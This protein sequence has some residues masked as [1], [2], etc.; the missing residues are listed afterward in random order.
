MR[1]I[2]LALFVFVLVGVAFWSCSDSTSE[3]QDDSTA[4]AVSIS[5]PS[6]Y[7]EFFEGTAVSIKADATDNI[8]VSKIEFIID[9][10]LEK[11]DSALPYEYLWNTT[12]KVGTHKIVLNAY[13]SSN[14]SSASDT[15]TVIIKEQLSIIVNT[16]N[17]GENW[18]MGYEQLIIWNGGSYENVKIDLYCGNILTRCISESTQNDGS[19]N[20]IVP[21]DLAQGSYKIRISNLLNEQIFDESNADFNIL[22]EGDGNDFSNTATSITAPHIGNYAISSSSDV[23]WYRIM[24]TAGSQYTFENISSTVATEF[25]LFGTGTEDGSDPGPFI[26]W[27]N[28]SD[29]TE[30]T[31]IIYTA[32]DSGFYFLKAGSYETKRSI[33]SADIFDKSSGVYTLS[34][35][36]IPDTTLPQIVIT[37][38]EDSSEYI[39]DVTVSIKAEATDNHKISKVE[40]YI[41]NVLENTD[42]TTPYEFLWNTTGNLGIHTIRAKAY[43]FSNNIAVSDEIE[44]SVLEQSP[45][46]DGMAFVIGGSFSMGDEIGDL[47]EG[48]RP[49]HNVYVDC[50]YMSKHE[51]TQSEW[52]QYMPVA[53]YNYGAGDN[54]PVYYISWYMIIKY[55]NLRSMAEG[56][57]PCYTINNSTNPSDWGS[58]PVETSSVW[59]S[60]ICNWSNNGYRLPTEAEWEYAARGGIHYTDYYYFS[61]SDN[62][63]DVCWYYYNNT[64]YGSK[65]VET[66]LPNQLGIFDMS[67]NLFEWCWDRYGEYSIESSINPTGPTTGSYHVRRGGRWLN[68]SPECRVAYRYLDNPAY[69]NYNYIG[70]RVSRT[71]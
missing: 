39:E 25:Y 55:C 48:C 40:Y 14:N 11:T 23:D 28:G 54:Y 4:P 41:D 7:D 35:S 12:G 51:V 6:N 36:I 69:N 20:W 60:V 45:P 1:N 22:T 53:T 42:E 5:S 38:P 66:K 13:D 46:I 17:G 3:P 31:S 43:D 21:S 64:P 57:T 52:A 34:V 47:L 10:S 70:F 67:G 37:Q 33:N 58:I 8:S 29:G 30:N 27:D 24:L 18:L 62:I 49:V 59:D 16:P 63:N 15:L 68:Y 61:G 50:F 56:L 2:F 9:D 65:P 26:L 44:I 71:R 19:Y 32:F